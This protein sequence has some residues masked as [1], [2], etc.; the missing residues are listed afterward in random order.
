MR[1]VIGLFKI[2]TQTTQ[3][4]SVANRVDYVKAAVEELKRYTE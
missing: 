1:L 4:V 2:N 3:N